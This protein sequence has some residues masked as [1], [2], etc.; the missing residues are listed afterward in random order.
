[1]DDYDYLEKAVDRPGRGKG[2]SDHGKV[3]MDMDPRPSTDSKHR[4]RQ[5]DRTVVQRDRSRERDHQRGPASEATDGRS[6]RGRE[7]QLRESHRGGG[8]D[9]G[10]K[11]RDGEGGR[12]CGNKAP[13]PSPE[14]VALKVS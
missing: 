13:A 3:D 12:A 8:Q 7:T 9:H 10:H 2:R 1:M 14:E 5:A 4:A 11:A 6:L